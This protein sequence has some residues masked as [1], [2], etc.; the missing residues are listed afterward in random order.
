MTSSGID[1]PFFRYIGYQCGI[2]TIE[3]SFRAEDET[4][5]RVHSPAD[6]PQQISRCY[7]LILHDSGGVSEIK[8]VYVA[9]DNRSDVSGDEEQRNR[10]RPSF[11]KH[12]DIEVAIRAGLAMSSAA[13]NIYGHQIIERS[14]KFVDYSVHVHVIHFGILPSL[15]QGKYVAPGRHDGQRR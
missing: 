8:K 6:A 11:H 15:K 13:E 1:M 4:L 12:S 9:A 14:F 5:E 3:F 10:I 2:R 7:N